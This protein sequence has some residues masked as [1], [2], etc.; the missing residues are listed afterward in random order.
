MLGQLFVRHTKSAESRSDGIHTLCGLENRHRLALLGKY[1]RDYDDI[2]RLL[3][4]GK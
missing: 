2:G 1:P 3:L 4:Y